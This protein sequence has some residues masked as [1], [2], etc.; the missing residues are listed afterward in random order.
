[1]LFLGLAIIVLVGDRVSAEVQGFIFLFF[2]ATG[3]FLAYQPKETQRIAGAFA[4]V[5]ISV[6]EI[7]RKIL[8]A[9]LNRQ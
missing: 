3:Y 6:I 5:V 4:D 8:L 2:I 7:L 1:M 9:I